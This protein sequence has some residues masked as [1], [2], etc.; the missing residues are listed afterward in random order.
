MSAVLFFL[1]LV[2]KVPS[3]WVLRPPTWRPVNPSTTMDACLGTR[4]HKAMVSPAVPGRQ[5]MAPCGETAMATWIVCA[6]VGLLGPT[7]FGLMLAYRCLRLRWICWAW[8]FSIVWIEVLQFEM[9][10][11]DG[12]LLGSNHRLVSRVPHDLSRTFGNEKTASQ[13]LLI[14][15]FL[16]PIWA[17]IYRHR[18]ITNRSFVHHCLHVALQLLQPITKCLQTHCSHKT[19]NRWTLG[20]SWLTFNKHKIGTPWKQAKRVHPNQSDPFETRKN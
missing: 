7:F 6:L 14:S 9:F 5:S 17:I 16:G 4:Y 20:A 18:T 10:F 1:L 3:H 12:R 15:F 8:L 2:E 13:W 11:S 19:A